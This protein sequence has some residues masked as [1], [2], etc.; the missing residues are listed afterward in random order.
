VPLPGF[1]GERCEARILRDVLALVAA[2][3]L[4]VSDCFGGSPPHQRN[5]EHPLG[6][7]MDAEPAVGAWDR[8][9]AMARA[10]GLG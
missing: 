8:T 9:M 4:H 1:P 6:L 10:A 2:Y 5:G 7:A 3:G